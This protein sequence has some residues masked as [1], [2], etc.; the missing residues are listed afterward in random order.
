MSKSIYIQKHVEK[1]YSSKNVLK[2][3]AFKNVSKTYAL[4]K[5]CTGGVENKKENGF[6][7][8]IAVCRLVLFTKTESKD[9]RLGV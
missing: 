6:S 9:H 4:K 2:K 8:M 1:T 3:H 7:Y 5:A